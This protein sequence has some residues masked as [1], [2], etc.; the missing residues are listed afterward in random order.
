MLSQSFIQFIQRVDPLQAP[1]LPIRDLRLR[2]GAVSLLLS[3]SAVMAGCAQ[4]ISTPL[5]DLKRTST[6]GMLIPAQQKQAME[7]MTRKKVEEEAQAVK[8]IEK[9]R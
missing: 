7:E 4:N 5:P 8:Q 3:L 9:S 1:L 6:D 2:F